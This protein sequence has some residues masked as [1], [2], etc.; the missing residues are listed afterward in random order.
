M[1]AQ[2]IIKLMQQHMAAVDLLKMCLPRQNN[3]V[4]GQLHCVYLQN[5]TG[6]LAGD[7]SKHAFGYSRTCIQITLHTAKAAKKSTKNQ[8]FVILPKS[9][10]S[11][12]FT[13]AQRCNAGTTWTVDCNAF[14]GQASNLGCPEGYVMNPSSHPKLYTQTSTLIKTLIECSLL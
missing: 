5:Q 4:L 2:D 7:P 6:D 11:Q 10:L 9:K 14:W 13:L 12:Y 8:W 3:H 1:T